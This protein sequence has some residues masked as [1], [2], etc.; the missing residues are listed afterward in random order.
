MI[1]ASS[2]APSIVKQCALLSIPR[3]SY[4]YKPVP[5][6]SE[7]LLLRR[8]IDE[9]FTENP[10]CG[11]RSIRDTLRLK[12]ITISRKCVSGHMREMGLVPI[13][14]KLNL[15]KRNLAHK[16]HP[17]LLRNLCINRV[18][19]VWSID[20]T[21]LRMKDGWMYLVAI[22]DWYSRKVISWAIDQ[23]MRAGFVLKCVANAVARYGT[24]EIINSDQ[25]SQFTCDD[26]IDLLKAYDIKIS[27]DGKGR[28]TDNNRIERFWRSL[29]QQAIY[30][31]EIESPFTMRRIITEYT[32]FYNER[33][34][35]QSLNGKT[36]SM[37]YDGIHIPTPISYAKK[38]TTPIL[39][40]A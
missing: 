32:D 28:A 40:A 2:D 27:M 6:S 14:P 8:Q 3:A 21:Y 13:Y 23:S 12:G 19:Q 16:I 38:K 36:P 25:G 20:I 29:K 17:Y 35:H 39:Q 4:Y 31:H 22:V 18:N 10:T 24:P 5:I 15:S 30:L 11:A 1:V 33:R 37:V 9:L 7:T 26:Y 34:P